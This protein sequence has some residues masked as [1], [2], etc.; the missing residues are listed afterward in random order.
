MFTPLFEELRAAGVPVSLR[1]YLT[2]LEAMEKG[3]AG[4]DI[5]AF[6]H[7]SRAILVKDETKIDA[8]D[9]VFAK[10]FKGLHALSPDGGEDVAARELPEEWLRLLAERFLSEEDRAKVEALGGFD[11][12]METL[13][14]RLAEQ[15]GRHQGGSKWIGTGGTSPFG[16]GGYNPEGVRI[17]GPGRHRRAVKVWE[18][19]EFR[20]LDDSVEI[21]TR[22]IRI[23]LRK[24]RQL[25]R[26]G[27][28]EELDIDE[29]IAATA[30]EG[31]LDVKTRR[32]R[33]NAIKVLLL[34]DIGGSMDDH[35]KV[36]EELFSAARS[37]FRS[38]THY[39]FHNCVYEGLW[40]EN[41]RR[42]VDQV[43]T[44]DIIRTFP[45]DTRLVIVGDAA[46]SPY[47]IAM[48]GGSVEHWNTE[49]GEVWLKRL[50]A[51]FP[52]A[53]WINPVRA[54]LWR[55]TQSTQMIASI[56]ERRMFELSL[57]GL[58]ATIDAL[59]R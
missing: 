23:A 26:T 19:R 5:E 40:R 44:E 55:Y 59:R 46:M 57:S 28:T 45:A 30:R 31:Y 36:C 15:E 24:L 54:D 58:D 7:L 17:G 29:T 8:F 35:I 20:D 4:T 53:A 33:Q 27:A 21:G 42:R 10:V 49:P 41:A 22:S 3:L 16:H 32:E 9:R 50:L 37:E 13:R 1:E 14:Q 11:K 56:M 25:A 34:L 2:L 6:Y 52:K 48:P 18:K 39:Y 12:L 47:E 43:P 38:L 51:H